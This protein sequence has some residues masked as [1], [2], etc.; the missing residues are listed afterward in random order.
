M[1]HDASS[2]SMDHERGHQ[3]FLFSEIVTKSFVFIFNIMDIRNLK[4]L[5]LWLG[6]IIF[7]GYGLTETTAIGSSTD[8]Q[9]ESGHYG[10]AGMLS[11]NIEAKIVDPDS[12]LALPPNR[13]GEL[14]LRGPTIM[15]G[16]RMFFPFFFLCSF[17]EVNKIGRVS[18]SWA[19]S[20]L[21]WIWNHF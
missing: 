11:P 2:G 9:E 10:T 1:L 16:G 4:S 20:V 13:R 5:G 21:N 17:S 7:Q 18:N 14:L 6:R 15:K 8:S 12:G 19:E 3:L